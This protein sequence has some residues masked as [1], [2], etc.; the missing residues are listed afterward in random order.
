M[1]ATDEVDTYNFSTKN[2]INA[3]NMCN[4]TNFE[5]ENSILDILDGCTVP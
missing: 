2:D 1:A 5:M 4:S 3:F